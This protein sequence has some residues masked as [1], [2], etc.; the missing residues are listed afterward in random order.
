MRKTGVVMASLAVVLSLAA[1][2]CAGESEEL[3]PV[4][5]QM[6]FLPEPSWGIYLNGIESGIFEEHGIDLELIPGQGSNFTMQQL[7]EGKADF[8]SASLIAYLANR[9]S[10]G[11]GTTAVFAPMHHPQA[12]IVTTAQADTLADLEGTTVGMIPFSVSNILLPLVLSENGLDP[13]SV[14][15]ESIQTSSPSLMFEGAV[16]GMEVY[17]GGNV[18]TTLKQAGDEGIDV[19]YID[20]HDYGL[21]GYANTIIVRD[22]ILDSDPDLVERMV[23]AIDESLSAA[24]DA[25]PQD[26]AALVRQ[27][28]P[29]YT[30][31]IVMLEWNDYRQLLADPGVFEESVVQTNLDYVADG[32]GIPHELTPA[33]VY[34]NEYVPGA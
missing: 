14:S 32:L 6:H 30:E 19:S 11:E 4:S 25:D 7:N 5:L 34:T 17:L 3:T 13:D 22:E 2:G 33:D 12:G 15:I 10:V 18:A 24:Q 29:E 23:A 28:A 8:G 20:L 21:V 9:A 26:L 16:D 1:V 27:R 31:E